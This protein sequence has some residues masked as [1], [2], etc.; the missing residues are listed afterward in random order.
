MVGGSTRAG[1][2]N[3]NK[4]LGRNQVAN[5]TNGSMILDATETSFEHNKF[6]AF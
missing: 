1:G 3:N 5:K 4:S 6:L 2:S